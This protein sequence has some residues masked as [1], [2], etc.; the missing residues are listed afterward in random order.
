MS[1]PYLGEVRLFPYNFA[2]VGWFECDGRLL[3][4]AEYEVLFNLIGTTYG[5][6]GVDTFGLPNLSGRVPVHQGQGGG[7]SNYVLGQSGGT[8][9]VTLTSAQLPAHTHAFN[10]VTSAASSPAPANTL[11][12]GAVSGE[13]LYTNNIA[14]IAS[15]NL[16]PSTV[17]ASGG[18][19]PH[20]NTMPSLVA[21][22]CIAWAG[23]Y[24]SQG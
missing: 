23:I 18:S 13:T 21:R 11:Q 15:G 9:T 1:T 10:A 16:A 8:E 4:I 2:P 17:G 19:L 14:G 5:G 20:D 24:P 7:L 3:P 6:N 22:Y 12:L